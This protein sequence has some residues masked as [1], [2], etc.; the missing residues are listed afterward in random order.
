MLACM[1]AKSWDLGVSE[2]LEMVEKRMKELVSSSQHL[3]TTVSLHVIEAGGKRLRPTLTILS[4][5]AMSGNKLKRMI[6][7]AA[8]MELIHS[9]TLVHDDI[10]D[11]AETRRGKKAAYKQ[12]GLHEA[13]VTGDFLFARAYSVGGTFGKEIVELVAKSTT[14]VA[15]GEMMQYV[16]K[17]DPKL[18]VDQYLKI[19]EGKT[20]YPIKTAAQLGVSL[21]EGHSEDVRAFGEYGLNLGIAFQIVDDVLDV[22]GDEKHL[23][24]MVGSDLREGNLTLPVILA[25]DKDKETAKCIKD[26]FEKDKPTD[27]DITECLK[28]VKKSGG[29]EKSMEIARGYA[30]GAKEYLEHAP[31]SKYRD[32]LLDLTDRVVSRTA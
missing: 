3:L 11:G 6:D 16:H 8:A 31:A 13:I 19:I 12:F 22:I 27:N 32:K 29:I 20:A 26:I 5:H 25:R 17:R 4:Y 7:I 1:N 14:Q 18:S 21:A 9:A 15:E 28:L 30:D 23:G 2:E 10:N 24:K